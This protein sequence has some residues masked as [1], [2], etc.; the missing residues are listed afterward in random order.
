VPNIA[1]MNHKQVKN[2]RYFIWK[3]S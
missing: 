2:Y 3:H 1:I